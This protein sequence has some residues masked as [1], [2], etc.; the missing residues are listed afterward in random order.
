M[1]DLLA[2]SSDT[3]SPGC[4]SPVS[5]SVPQPCERSERPCHSVYYGVGYGIPSQFDFPSYTETF[6]H[7]SLWKRVP[8]RPNKS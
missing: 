4:S 7:S 6:T 2:G 3:G 8:E 5:F 1:A